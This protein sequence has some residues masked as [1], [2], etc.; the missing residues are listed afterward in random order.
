M[1]K[2]D[3]DLQEVLQRVPLRAMPWREIQPDGTI[4]PYK[5]MV[6]EIMLQQTQ[7]ARVIPKYQA[8]I[9]KFPN[10]A[11][12]AKAPL[13]E[14]L[15][16][17]SGLG[18]NRRAKFLHEAAKQLSQQEFPQ[19][20]D[21]LVKLPGIGKNTAGAMIVYAYNQPE[22]FVETNI[23][24][25]YIHHYFHDQKDIPDTAILA[26]LAETLDKKQPREFYWKLMDYG[27][28]LKK[29][30]GNASQ[31]SKVYV[32][33][34]KFQGSNRQVRGHIL[35][36]LAHQDMTDK[37]LQESIPDDRLQDVLEVLQVEGLI[38]KT[39]QHYSLG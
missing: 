27:T 25:V 14:V 37:D 22:L 31:K 18:Y 23:R 19:T 9:E 5:V 35:R 33:Q 1:A 36:E 29:E 13:S 4:D 21:E 28:S 26:R 30:H 3:T 15:K 38:T 6:S 16:V 32:K 39:K 24:T 11:S 8:F 12:L 10:V 20:I 34:S 7:V 2:V 17:W